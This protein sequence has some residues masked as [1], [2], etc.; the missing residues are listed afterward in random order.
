MQIRAGKGLIGSYIL[1]IR[2]DSNGNTQSFDLRNQSST[3][4]SYYII[5]NALPS[6]LIILLLILYHYFSLNQHIFVI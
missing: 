6:F 2:C 3:I 1:S 4:I 5:I